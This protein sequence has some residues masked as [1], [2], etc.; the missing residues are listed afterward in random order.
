[1]KKDSMKCTCEHCKCGSMHKKGGMHHGGRGEA[2]YGLGI[3][4]AA[5]Y[6]ITAA[7]GFWM[8]VVG[9]IKAVF[10]PAFLV[11]ELMKMLN[12]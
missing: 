4:G 2:V 8:G 9:V 7:T 11:F 1:M 10:W 5:V 3:V 12:M 6:Y